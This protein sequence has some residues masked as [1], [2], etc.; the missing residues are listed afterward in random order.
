[1]AWHNFN[2]KDIYRIIIR[3]LLITLV[4]SCSKCRWIFQRDIKAFINTILS[5]IELNY[6]SEVQGYI[7]VRKIDN[8]TFTHVGH[9]DIPMSYL[10]VCATDR[11]FRKKKSLTFY[12]TYSFCCYISCPL[13][14][15]SFRTWRKKKEKPSSCNEVLRF[16]KITTH[17]NIMWYAEWQKALQRPSY[18]LLSLCL[19]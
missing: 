14:R 3:C 7:S 8:I 12:S 16:R 2:S 15:S 9:R 10:T 6:L 5:Q 4:E 18:F 19:D 11:T 13:Y 1:M 17:G